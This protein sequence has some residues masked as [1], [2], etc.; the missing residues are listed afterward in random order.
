MILKKFIDFRKS[1]NN[2]EE[3]NEN[4]QQAKTYIRNA[5]LKN[6]KERMGSKE[7]E[8]VGLSQEEIR[9]AD[10]NPSF[11]KVLTLVKDAQPLAY[12]F[13]KFFFEDLAEMEEDDRISELRGLLD[14]LKR[15][16]SSLPNLP[17]SVERYVS[18]AAVEEEEKNSDEYGDDIEIKAE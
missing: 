10:N 3:L 6:K 2:I 1:Y 17:M 18:R 13:T 4:V 8:T 5:A 15:L 14:K 16:R 9:A 11:Q 7:G 12:V